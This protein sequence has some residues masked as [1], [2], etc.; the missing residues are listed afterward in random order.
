MCASVTAQSVCLGTYNSARPALLSQCWGGGFARNLHLKQTPLGDSDE[1]LSKVW[2]PRFQ[3]LGFLGHDSSELP[4]QHAPALGPPACGV[5][6]TVLKDGRGRGHKATGD[7]EPWELL[8]STP[9]P[10]SQL[11]G[12]RAQGA[13]LPGLEN[14][15]D[16]I[17]T[18]KAPI[19]NKEKIT[20]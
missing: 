17:S 9:A 14:Q 7:T 15:R 6:R 13:N 1:L 16:Y 20:Q 4:L 5:T 2:E 12:G 11:D 18:S 8:C 10:S 3:L 19:W